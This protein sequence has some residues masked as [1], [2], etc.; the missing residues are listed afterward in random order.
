MKGLPDDPTIQYQQT[1]NPDGNYPETH[2]YRNSTPQRADHIFDVV[3]VKDKRVL[4]L[5]CNEGFFCF[6]A[7]KQGAK[8]V[9]GVDYFPQAI[10]HCKT[11]K[12][13]YGIEHSEFQCKDLNKLDE[14]KRVL[15]NNSPEI[16]LCLSLLHHL[17]QPDQT[18]KYLG[19]AAPIIIFEFVHND[20]DKY[21]AW[22]KPLLGWSFDL[23]VEDPHYYASYCNDDYQ[24]DRR[25][26]IIARDRYHTNRWLQFHDNGDLNRFEVDQNNN[27]YKYRVEGEVL[28]KQRLFLR[29]AERFDRID[30][31][32]I[33]VRMNL[34]SRCLYILRE[35]RA[36]KW[37]HG[38]LYRNILIESD[39]TLYPIDDETMFKE[40]DESVEHF[41]HRVITHNPAWGKI[42]PN[43]NLGITLDNLPHFLQTIDLTHINALLTRL[44]IPSIEEAEL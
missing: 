29:Q 42:S 6:E 4:D 13:L 10:D 1:W 36:R 28:I 31:T 5:G 37:V 21:L 15:S 39:G 2:V 40:F 3:V 26:V 38:E 32:K 12:Q 43:D 27:F 20:L 7:V 22:L 11:T 41:Y 16:I 25:A 19:M 34:R 33:T 35:Y 17:D 30:P 8:H 24:G 44:G 23:C 9:V 14:L 18:V